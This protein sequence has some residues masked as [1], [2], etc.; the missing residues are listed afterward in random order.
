[1]VVVQK[2]Q[3]GE[4]N[5]TLRDESHGKGDCCENQSTENVRSPNLCLS[6]FI[7]SVSNFFP[8]FYQKLHTIFPLRCDNMMEGAIVSS[9]QKFRG[10]CRRTLPTYLEYRNWRKTVEIS[11]FVLYSSYTKLIRIALSRI[12]F[13]L[14]AWLVVR[15][16]LYYQPRMKELTFLRGGFI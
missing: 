3:Y 11:S 1:M 8:K 2:L 12:I 14:V 7:F 9:I 16:F 10:P 15:P 13:G 4:Q 6:C 5:A